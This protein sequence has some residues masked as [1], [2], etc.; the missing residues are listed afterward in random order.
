MTST[1]HTGLAA[2]T[3]PATESFYKNTK[4]GGVYKI[5]GKNSNSSNI[6]KKKTRNILN[7]NKQNEK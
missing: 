5:T 4:Q 1:L 6:Y 2:E 7:P 3:Y